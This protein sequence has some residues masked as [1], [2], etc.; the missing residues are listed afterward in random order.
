M[1]PVGIPWTQ[2]GIYTIIRVLAEGLG[3]RL[4]PLPGKHWRTL[5]ALIDMT[6]IIM[7][8]PPFSYEHDDK[9]GGSS[10]EL[11]VGPN[12]ILAIGVT[13]IVICIGF[14]MWYI[15]F[16]YREAREL[17]AT[18]RRLFNVAVAMFMGIPS[19]MLSMHHFYPYLEMGAAWYGYK[20][21]DW[22]YIIVRAALPIFIGLGA[23]GVMSQTERE[24][25]EEQTAPEE[26][27]VKKNVDNV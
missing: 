18:N 26:V 16:I 8:F 13:L 3:Q 14:I 22:H 23:W 10:N 25:G 17:R 9:P 12:T 2:I 19:F 27:A 21:T 1:R 5:C 15:I 24:A 11:P 20:L 4:F 6:V 7:G